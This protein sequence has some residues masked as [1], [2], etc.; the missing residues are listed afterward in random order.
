MAENQTNRPDDLENTR[1]GQFIQDLLDS[2]RKSGEYLD[3]RTTRLPV[4]PSTDVPAEHSRQEEA[5]MRFIPVTESAQ[6]EMA[7]EMPLDEFFDEE[8]PAFLRDGED[9]PVAAVEEK[10]FFD[11]DEDPVP[12]LSGGLLMPTLKAAIYVISVLL[13][14]VLL[15]LGVWM[16]A[17]DIFGLTDGDRAVTVTVAE[18]DT[19][20]DVT[21][22]LKDAGLIKH[23]LLFRFYCALTDAGQKIDPGIYELNDYYDY[24][25]LVNGMIA[26]SDARKTVT[27]TIPEGYEVAQI[28]QLLADNG[29][30]DYEDLC[31]KAANFDFEY[32]FLNEV[33]YG[34]INRLEGYLFP[35]TYEFYMHDDAET[36]LNKFLRN[37][38]NKM[39][40]ELYAQLDVLNERLAAN[41]LDKSLTLRDVLSVA[42]MIEKEAATS[43]ERTSIA[44]VI[45]NR[46][47]SDNFS[48]LQID[49][50]V[51]YA[52]GERKEVLTYADLEV[53]SPYNTYLYEGLPVGPIA[54]PGLSCIKAALYPAD[55]EFY[56]YAL[57]LDGTHH[58][59]RTRQ[60]HEQFLA[61]LEEEN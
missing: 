33:P 36:V 44:S 46:L 28:L 26:T 35:D 22:K 51:Q 57:D 34:E 21:D 11:A 14:A 32:D 52:L 45:Y 2:G 49:A 42:S 24:M 12:E 5:T 29:A 25:A 20:A 47:C 15:A 54:C 56:Y 19:V 23:K 59:S 39:T 58:F 37:F 18:T 43:G 8:L 48:H 61:A 60:E 53:D 27:I 40:E 30:A 17:D 6:Q 41:G 9:S 31:D 16:A 7:E 3:G 10:P 38:N 50:T 4:I 1:R 13:G 55:T